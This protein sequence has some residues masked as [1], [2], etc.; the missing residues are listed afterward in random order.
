MMLWKY[1]L[2]Y[3]KILKGSFLIFHATHAASEV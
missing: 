2:A 3:V 1:L